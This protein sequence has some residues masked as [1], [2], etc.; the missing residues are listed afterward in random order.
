MYLLFFLISNGVVNMNLILP[1][2]GFILVI[3]NQ[4]VIDHWSALHPGQT[5][6]ISL[7]DPGTTC[8]TIKV[9]E[10]YSDMIDPSPL[11]SAVIFDSTCDKEYRR[12]HWNDTNAKEWMSRLAVRGGYF[13][14]Y[15]APHI[16]PDLNS[17]QWDLNAYES[18]SYGV[19][20]TMIC[21]AV[22]KCK[23]N[24]T[25]CTPIMQGPEWYLNLKLPLPPAR[26]EAAMLDRTEYTSEEIEVLTKTDTSL[27]DIAQANYKVSEIESPPLELGVGHLGLLIASGQLAGR[28]ESPGEP[29]HVMRGISRKVERTYCDDRGR[30]VTIENVEVLVRTVDHRGVI[31]EYTA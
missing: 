27:I 6:G 31:E 15:G 28:I 26:R 7:Q 2:K 11:F 22:C 9:D 8:R 1:P 10:E 18:I 23:H 30:D 13:I 29:P 24:P 20:D 14:L 19:I 21:C 25:E 17:W 3:G 5:V 16:M 4:N 12:Y